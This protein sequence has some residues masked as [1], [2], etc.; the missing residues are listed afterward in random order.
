MAVIIDLVVI[1]LIM[2]M[3]YALMSEGLWGAALMFFNALFST[4]ITLNCYE[5]LAKLIGVNVSFLSGYA[6]ALCILVIF[7]VSLLVIRLITEYLAPSMVRYPAPV[8]HIGRVGFAFSGAVLTASVM[9]LALDASPVDKKILGSIDAKSKPLYG[10]RLDKE[11]LAFFQFQS[12]QIFTRT[13]ASR[14]PFGQYGNSRVFDPHGKWIYNAFEARPY[15]KQ[16]LLEEDKPAA[17]GGAEGGAAPPDGAAPA[18]G[19]DSPR[20][21]G[22]TAGA[23]AGLAPTN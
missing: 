18:A 12:G 4:L 10:Y 9:L 1:V 21:P 13:A 2:G 22:G 7:T 3:T 6:D 20:V 5:P 15:G 8:Y 19:K 16:S 17:E 23:A 11:L 14:D